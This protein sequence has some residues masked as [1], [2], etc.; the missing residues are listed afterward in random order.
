MAYSETFLTKLDLGLNRWNEYNNHPDNMSKEPYQYTDRVRSY[1][2]L[3]N[4]EAVC[5]KLRN[6]CWKL[7][8]AIFLKELAFILNIWN[9]E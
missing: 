6:F 7:I 8:L 3:N 9:V 2:I 4:R 5:R 1:E